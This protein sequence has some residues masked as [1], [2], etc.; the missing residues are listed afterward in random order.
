MCVCIYYV[1]VSVFYVCLCVYRSNP[2][3]LIPTPFLPFIY[4]ETKP[5]IC[6]IFRPFTLIQKHTYRQTYIYRQLNIKKLFFVEQYII[7]LSPFKSG[8]FFN[9]KTFILFL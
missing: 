4:N 5:F 7:S 8:I 9:Q 3:Y 1:C 2:L 6:L